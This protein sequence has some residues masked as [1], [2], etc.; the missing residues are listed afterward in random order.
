MRRRQRRPDDGCDQYC[1]LEV[2][3][4]NVT[5]E[6]EECDDGNDDP[7]DGCNECQSTC[8][9]GSTWRRARNAT[10]PGG[11]HMCTEAEFMSNPSQ[12]GCDTQCKRIVCG[13]EITQR[14]AEECDPAG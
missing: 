6:G 11:D 14:P 5:Q 1:F 12:C 2:C 8:G 7:D 10:R 9:N 3:G 4:N 13:N